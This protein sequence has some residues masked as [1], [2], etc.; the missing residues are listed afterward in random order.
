MYL[1]TVYFIME[2]ASALLFNTSPAPSVVCGSKYDTQFRQSEG[3]T[4]LSK[5]NKPIK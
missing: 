3:N 2:Y 5:T 1:E 4:N